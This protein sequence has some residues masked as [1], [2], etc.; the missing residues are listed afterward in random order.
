MTTT[1][2]DTR[3]FL[4]PPHLLP[5]I[6]EAERAFLTN[7]KD[8]AQRTQL[9]R[10]FLRARWSTVVPIPLQRLRHLGGLPKGNGTG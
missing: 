10:R 5:F 7:G 1:T 6:T 3:P 9:P 4:G 8:H 2:P